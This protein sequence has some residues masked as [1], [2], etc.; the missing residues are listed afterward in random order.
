M[1]YQLILQ[2]VSSN[3][4]DICKIP[5]QGH[6]WMNPV[7]MN[8]VSILHDVNSYQ[9]HCMKGDELVAVMPLYERRRLT[10]KSLINPV[11]AYYQGI[12]FLQN[13]ASKAR[14][15][16]DNLAITEAIAQF[17]NARYGSLCINLYPE[18]IDVRGF[19][20]NK[21][22][23]KPLYTFRFKSGS[24]LAPVSDEKRKLSMAQK[25]GYTFREEYDLDRLIYMQK[26]M[27]ERKKHSLGVSY[28]K[29]RAFLDTLHQ[30]NLMQQFNVYDNA[31]IVSSDV[32]F[33][34]EGKT[35][36]AILRASDEEAMLKGA[37]SLHTRELLGA[38]SE[39]YEVI[40][41]CGANIPEV[42]RFKAAMGL[43]LTAFYQ[44]QK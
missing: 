7:F 18:N 20:W 23:A 15:L 1:S 4:Q 14:Q 17:L 35:A 26:Q 22:K 8:A 37:S 29:F 43:E 38:L 27:D 6:F 9:L 3:M 11:G 5:K 12:S 39:K 31:C 25:A 2:E 10:K 36:Y 13:R 42:A 30:A 40:D 34:E 19:T 44:I 41:F 21:L 28:P 24:K 32:L 33:A 16:L